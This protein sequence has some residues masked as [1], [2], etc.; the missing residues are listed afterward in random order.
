MIA[1]YEGTRPVTSAFG[2]F[3]T[4]L[5]RVMRGTIA[6]AGSAWLDQEIRDRHSI[7]AFQ[8]PDKV[9]DAIRL[10]FSDPLWPSLAVSLGQPAETL[11]NR[12]ILIVQRRNKIAHEADLDPTYP[13]VYWP[14]APADVTDA[15]DFIEQ[16]CEAIHLLV[17]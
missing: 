4:C 6:G 9:A 16:L 14:I 17:A 1:I 8:Q 3:D 2:E 11:K 15:T 10:M 13:G 5:Y 12:L 7:K